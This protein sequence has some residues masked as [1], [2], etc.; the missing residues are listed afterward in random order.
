MPRI[1]SIKPEFWE[2]EDIAKLPPYARLL[3][4]ASWNFAD[5]EG[6]LRWNPAWLGAQAFPYDLERG[7]IT[8]ASVQGWMTLLEDSGMVHAYVGSNGQR[9]GWIVNFRKHQ[10]INKPT[11]SR[12]PRPPEDVLADPA[13]VHNRRSNVTHLNVVSDSGNDSRSDSGSD[14]G[15]DY[16]LGTR[17]REQGTG[18][19]TRSTSSPVDNVRQP[20]PAPEPEPALPAT[21]ELRPDVEA[22]CER[23]H[24][25]LVET[26]Y[27]PL[28]KITDQWRVQARLILDKDERNFDQ[29][30]RLIAW[31]LDDGF[32]STNIA[33]MGKFR[34][35]YPKLLAA[36]RRE[37]AGQA[38]KAPTP[39][40]RAQRLDAT[41]ALI[42]KL[43]DDE[44]NAAGA[45][46]R[47]A[48]QA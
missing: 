42:R 32:W 17:N 48:I 33:S 30:M 11:R 7:D 19:E 34:T 20:E 47:K 12:L 25:K 29:A 5:D 22:L 9:Y 21:V 39:S 37:H 13:T 14:A 8:I 26:D 4:V 36:A 18:N 1:R 16:F 35:Q 24:A 10:V 31:A 38:R 3:F 44:R 6:L 41:A 2:H 28:P 40:P 45:L 15:S 43:E 23:L 27:K 46:T